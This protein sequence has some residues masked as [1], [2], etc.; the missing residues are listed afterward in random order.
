VSAV[1]RAVFLAIELK[2]AVKARPILK[3]ELAR[4]LTERGL[5]PNAP[6]RSAASSKI[7]IRSASSARPAESIRPSSP[8]VPKRT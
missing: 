1:E 3:S 7:A 5:S 4:T 6:V 8:S 2:L